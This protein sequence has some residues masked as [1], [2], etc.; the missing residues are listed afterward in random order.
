M[1]QSV[2]LVNAV[3]QAANAGVHHPHCASFGPLHG[4]SR[5]LANNHFKHCR[6]LNTDGAESHT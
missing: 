6:L 2:W 1:L 3:I 4:Q 5:I